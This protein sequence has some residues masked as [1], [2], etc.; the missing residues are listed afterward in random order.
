[1]IDITVMGVSFSGDLNDLSP[2][3]SKY[4][5]MFNHLGHKRKFSYSSFRIY[6]S[7]V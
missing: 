6:M 1:M 4:R 7:I 3:F 2:F 5:Q